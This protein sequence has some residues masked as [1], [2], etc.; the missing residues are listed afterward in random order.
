[1]GPHSQLPVALRPVNSDIN[2]IVGSVSEWLMLT[3]AL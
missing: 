1:M 3:E 2:S